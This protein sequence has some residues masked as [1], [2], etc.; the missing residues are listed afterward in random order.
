MESQLKIFTAYHTEDKSIST[1][2][3]T[4]DSLYLWINRKKTKTQGASK[5]YVK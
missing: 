5:N 2:Y 3:H 1:T 4:K